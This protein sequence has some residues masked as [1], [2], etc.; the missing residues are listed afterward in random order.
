MKNLNPNRNLESSCSVNRLEV[1]TRLILFNGNHM[2]GSKLNLL[3]L[4]ILL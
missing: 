4:F 1:N 3:N 2:T